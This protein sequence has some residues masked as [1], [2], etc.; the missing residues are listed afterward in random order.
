MRIRVLFLAAS[1]VFFTACTVRDI[2]AVRCSNAVLRAAHDVAQAC[3]EP[4]DEGLCP[5]VHYED[6]DED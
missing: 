6:D 2:D 3:L 4:S 1:I 5:I